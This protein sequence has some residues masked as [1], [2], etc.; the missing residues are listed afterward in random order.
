MQRAHDLAWHAAGK[1]GEKREGGGERD[2]GDNRAGD[3]PTAYRVPYNRRRPNYKEHGNDGDDVDAEG[4]RAIERNAEGCD[5]LESGE[6]D[7]DEEDETAGEAFAEILREMELRIY[8]RGRRLEGRGGG[9]TRRHLRG[10]LATPPSAT[11]SPP[12]A[13]ANRMWG[14]PNSLMVRCSARRSPKPR[15]HVCPTPPGRGGLFAIAVLLRERGKCE[16]TAG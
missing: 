12:Q 1:A 6:G 5:D 11:P 4:N 14:S 13:R 15:A 9:R 10:H 16:H 8:G 2:E 7:G 3:A